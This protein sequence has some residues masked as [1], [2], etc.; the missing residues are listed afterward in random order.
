MV[1]P[2]SNSLNG[3]GDDLGN[4][5][6]NN[7]KRKG[8][9]NRNRSATEG[10]GP[11]DEANKFVELI[12]TGPSKLWEANNTAANTGTATT[13][14]RPVISISTSSVYPPQRRGGGPSGKKS[15]TFG[16]KLGSVFSRSRSGRSLSSARSMGH[17]PAFQGDQDDD[18]E[19]DDGGVDLDEEGYGVIPEGSYPFSIPL[20]E[21]LPPSVEIEEDSTGFRR[22][23]GLKGIS[24][25]IVASLAVKPPKK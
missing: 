9:R 22:R 13:A 17:L 1:P 14:L 25:Q 2:P 15:T 24:Y 16:A 19:D 18:D 5:R 4:D 23:A 8:G 20:P 7:H 11:Q 21:G 6:R 12:G 10:G 3:H